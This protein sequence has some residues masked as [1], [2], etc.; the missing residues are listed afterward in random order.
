L[1]IETSLIILFGYANLQLDHVGLGWVGSS[2]FGWIGMVVGWFD[3]VGLVERGPTE[4]VG[5]VIYDDSWKVI[6]LK[7]KIQKPLLKFELMIY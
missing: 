2:D 6:L 3:Q 5:E 1:A 7:G 4:V